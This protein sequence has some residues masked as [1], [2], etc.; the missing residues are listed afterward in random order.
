MSSGEARDVVVQAVDLLTEAQLFQVAELEGD[1]VNYLLLDLRHVSEKVSDLPGGWGG[2][3]GGRG[4]VCVCPVGVGV[5]DI[6]Q[7]PSG[8]SSV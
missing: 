7:R 8:G 3:G 6:H 2:H 5:E 4:E 1:L